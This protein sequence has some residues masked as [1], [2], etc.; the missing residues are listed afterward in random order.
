MKR[1][2]LLGCSV[3]LCGTALTS[4]AAVTD[5]TDSVPERAIVLTNGEISPSQLEHIAMMYSRENLAF[6]DPSAPR[7][8]FLDKKGKVA[9]GIGGN[10]KAIAMYDFDGA[11][12]EN[13]FTTFDI[14]VPLNPGQ[15]QRLGATAAASSIFL[16]LVTAPTR[17]GRVIVYFQTDFKGDNGGYG[18]RVKQAYV[19]VGNLTA[20]KARS[21]FSDAPAM[22]PTIDDQGPSGQVTAK[23]LLIQYKTPSYRGLSGAISLEIPSAGYTVNE[24]TRSIAQ[25]FP[26]IPA[27]V[28][29]A[30]DGGDSHVRASGILRQLSYRDLTDNRNRFETGWGV[31]I[32]GVSKIVGGLQIFG[33]YTYGKGIAHY[34]N[35]LADADLDLIPGSENGRMTAPGV[36]GWTAGARYDFTRNF[37]VTGSYSQA[38]LY[39]SPRLGADTYRYG[40]YAAV[41]AFYDLGDLRLGVEYLYGSRKNIDRQDGHA[42]RIEALVQYSF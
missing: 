36:A 32:S 27:Y 14:P 26:D 16:K 17:L 8:L 30:W 19:S 39:N 23:N 37:F 11:V 22:A 9:L 2:Q 13:G 29:Y 25:R 18:V 3:L 34:I 41:N 20:G 5:A 42:N 12:N 10:L 40:Q 38:R 28:Q 33:H 15:R 4:S 31:Q 24:A 35:D 1:I 6:E 21:T 7:F